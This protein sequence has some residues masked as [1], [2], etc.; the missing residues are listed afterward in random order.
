MTFMPRPTHA[1]LHRLAWPAASILAVAILSACSFTP[2]EPDDAVDDGRA[3]ELLSWS[4]Q[5][6][7]RDGWLERRHEMLLPMMRRHGIDMWIVVN[8]EFHDDP[9]TEYVA[10]ARPYTGRRDVFVFVDAGE[11]GLRKVAATGYWEETV[12][13][14]FE[15]P[16]DPLPAQQVLR[17][18]YDEYHPQAIGLGMGGSRGVTRSLT[19][20]AYAFL[21]ES[22]GPQAQRHFVSAAPLIEEYLATRIPEEFEPYESLVALTEDITRRALS[23]EV[24][25]PGV[26]TVGD[27]R[28]WMYDELW[29]HG[30][31][32]WFQPDMRVQRRQVEG[33]GSRGFL[34]VAPAE[35]VIER[36]DVI[37]IDFGISYMGLDSD[38][39][40]MAYVLLPDEVDVPAGMKAAMANTNAL[41]DA[42]AE[43]S[44]PGK[45]AGQAYEETMA[46]M[47]AAGIS[48]QIYSHPLGN[49]GHGLGPSIDFRS[50][51]RADMPS[52]QLV[53]GSYISI[54]LNTRTPV[55]EWDGQDV[56]VMAED[57]AYL[58]AEGWRFFRPRQ[59]EWYL[60]R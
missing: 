35:T 39:Q 57:P 5:M 16:V 34:A 49:Q 38:W 8:E 55:A 1:H 14:F 41:Q 21:A 44:R 29:W 18:L 17:N 22:M 4:E 15:S 42:L 23:N 11:A 36:G 31:R 37:H 26:T 59:E 12:S 6:D 46:A 32:T 45:T 25:E 28:R 56:V 30:V 54:E 7:V 48:A 9:L 13:R 60:I 24:I 3:A 43:A 52:G 50:A 33:V 40:K 51:G 20:D 10:P 53:E 2:R 47:E 19:H 27:V 58:T